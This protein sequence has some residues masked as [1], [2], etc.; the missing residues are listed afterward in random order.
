MNAPPLFGLLVEF[1]RPEQVLNA[2]R[3]AWEAGYR[4][5]DAY[6]PYPV[7]GLAAALGMK[8]GGIPSI[9]FCGAAVGAGVGFLMQYY[10]MVVDYPF[11]SG[12]RP[13]NSWPAFIPVTFEALIL[14]ASLSAFLG[15]LFLNGL[16]RPNHPIFN[17]PGFERASQDRFFL[18]IEATDP[19]FDPRETLLFLGQLSPERPVVEV[20]NEQKIEPPAPEAR[21]D[22]VPEARI[23]ATQSGDR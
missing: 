10:S 8:R 18:C 7:E 5:M 13:L 11:N 23:P 1:A 22:L 17:A 19:R 6:S 14:I 21:A 3:A 2:T 15:M 4:D 9:V 12:G 20:F 16:P